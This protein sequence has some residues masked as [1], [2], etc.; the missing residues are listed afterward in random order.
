[1]F[2][3]LVTTKTTIHTQ[4]LTYQGQELKDPPVWESDLVLGDT[5]STV[6]I[7]QTVVNIKCFKTALLLTDHREH[8]S[9]NRNLALSETCCPMG[10]VSYSPWGCRVG[11]DLVTKQQD[12][13]SSLM[14]S[15]Q[16]EGT[17]K[18]P[19]L[20]RRAH[21]RRCSVSP[22]CRLVNALV[23]PFSCSLYYPDHGSLTGTEVSPCG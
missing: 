11:H 16:R 14:T 7:T 8:S 18:R 1:M 22:L 5:H 19:V 10:L 13:T 15:A 23:S 20:K 4:S 2:P 9:T 21:W 3:V 17:E 12:Y 6:T